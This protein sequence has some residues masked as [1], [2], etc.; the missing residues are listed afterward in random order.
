MLNAVLD[1]NLAV[2]QAAEVLEVK[3]RVTEKLPRAGFLLL[4]GF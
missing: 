3:S 2:D 1:R 4:C